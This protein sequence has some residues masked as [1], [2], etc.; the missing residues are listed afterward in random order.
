MWGV[1]SGRENVE[2]REGNPKMI[3]DRGEMGRVGIFFGKF[4][5]VVGK[6]RPVG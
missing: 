3:E 1:V 4:I 6:I 2:E 5:R